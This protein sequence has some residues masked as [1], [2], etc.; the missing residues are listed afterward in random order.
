MCAIG[1][2]VAGING[3]AYRELAGKGRKGRVCGC[4]TGHLVGWEL[5][6]VCKETGA[7][8]QPKW[9]LW[10]LPVPLGVLCGMLPSKGERW[11]PIKLCI[12]PPSA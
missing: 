10:G 4:S 7:C 1:A 6:R 2:V 9:G 12:S 5:P 3:S 8:S 11:S